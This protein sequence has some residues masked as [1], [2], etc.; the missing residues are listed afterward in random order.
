[1]ANS[2]QLFGLVIASLAFTLV[3]FI[4]IILFSGAKAQGSSGTV[5]SNAIAANSIAPAQKQTFSMATAYKSGKF[6]LENGVSASPS[7]LYYFY[8]PKGT[9]KGNPNDMAMLAGSNFVSEVIGLKAAGV[10]LVFS[11][12]SC[13]QSAETDFTGSGFFAHAGAVEVSSGQVVCAMIK[14]N[15]NSKTDIKVTG[16]NADSIQFSQ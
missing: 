13:A 6:S 8:F 1:M 10:A 7:N 5:L 11:P 4:G 15:A 12:K 2:K 3:F 9:A 14:G 16:L